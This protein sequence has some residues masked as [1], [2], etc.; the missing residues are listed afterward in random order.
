MASPKRFQLFLHELHDI[1]ANAADANGNTLSSEVRKRVARSFYQDEFIEKA[2]D[3]YPDLRT[4]LIDLKRKFNEGINDASD[5][6]NN[7][8]DRTRQEPN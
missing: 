1:T 5:G 3:Q 7:S 4:L 8:D 6:P 2:L